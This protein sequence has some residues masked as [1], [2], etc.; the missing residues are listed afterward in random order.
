MKKLGNILV[1]GS[2][3]FFLET[4]IEMYILTPLYG[5]QMLFF[6]LIHIAP[7]L[8]MIVLGLS[9]M[10]YIALIIFMFFWLVKSMIKKSRTSHEFTTGSLMILLI[11][12]VHTTLLLTYERWAPVLFPN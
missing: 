5:K 3:L 1:T 2:S 12:I 4:A 8:M 11:L 9:A 10:A 6:S 7:P